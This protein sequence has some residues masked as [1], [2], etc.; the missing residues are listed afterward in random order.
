MANPS[1]PE[2]AV[3]RLRAAYPD[4]TPDDQDT[5]LRVL[6][7]YLPRR[8]VRQLV[9]LSWHHVTKRARALS[10]LDPA[11]SDGEDDAEE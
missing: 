6:L 1:T 10:L 2:E 9:G 7:G 5:L 3:A 8:Q 11:A 4:M